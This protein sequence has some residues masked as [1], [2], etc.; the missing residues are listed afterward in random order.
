MNEA[1][2]NAHRIAMHL[3][4]IA[5]LLPTLNEPS[6]EAYL[7]GLHRDDVHEYAAMLVRKAIA[8]EG[9]CPVRTLTDEEQQTVRENL[10]CQLEDRSTREAIED[11]TEGW[12]AADWLEEWEMIAE[13]LRDA[14]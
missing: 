14:M 1:T 13:D 9:A 3:R 11:C 2:L 10:S 7:P 6:L 8:L 4:A 12:T 5:P